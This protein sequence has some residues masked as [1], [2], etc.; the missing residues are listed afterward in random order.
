MIPALV[1]LLR[2]STPCTPR[3]CSG[4]GS[5]TTRLTPAQSAQAGSKI[6]PTCRRRGCT[7]VLCLMSDGIDRLIA[8]IKNGAPGWTPGTPPNPPNDCLES[9]D[10]T[11]SIPRHARE[12]HAGDIITADPD[13]ENR[14][15]RWRASN[16][17]EVTGDGVAI[18][19]YVDQADGVKGIAYYG[20]LVTLTVEPAGG[21]Q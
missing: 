6:L 18:I 11:R 2:R 10:M 16:R 21:A 4:C 20:G 14:P 7:G 13:H 12:I 17:A 3:V 9:K 15:V 5:V 19:D 1:A 8:D